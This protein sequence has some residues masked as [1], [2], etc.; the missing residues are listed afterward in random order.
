M[1]PSEKDS[2]ERLRCQVDVPHDSE[3][4]IAREKV[5]AAVSVALYDVDQLRI[6]LA[7]P[8][9]YMQ[10]LGCVY[11]FMS[12]YG[13]TIFLRRLVDSQVAWSI[14]YSPVVWSS[15]THWHDRHRTNPHA[16]SARQCFFYAQV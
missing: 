6:I 4:L 14:P 11:E 10:G 5:P 16:V 2:C 8:I 1:V 15:D 3:L 7:Q 9:K 12:N 13:E